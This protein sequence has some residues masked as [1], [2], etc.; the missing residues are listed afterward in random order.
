MGCVQPQAAP[1]MQQTMVQQ[2][3][4]Q[5]Q[6]S[7]A[8]LQSSGLMPG[9]PGAAGT[10]GVGTPGAAGVGAGVELSSLL[11]ALGQ[12]TAGQPA[13]PAGGKHFAEPC[14]AGYSLL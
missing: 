5:M 12:P 11:S 1:Q 4:M 8:Q 6:Q 2:A 9:T 3:M 10:P 7:M 13:A 14:I